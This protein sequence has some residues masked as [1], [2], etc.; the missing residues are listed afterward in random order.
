VSNARMDMGDV[1]IEDVYQ[2]YGP[3]LLRRARMLL[4]DEQ[5]AWDA[6]QEVFVR[7]LQAGNQFR[8]EAS[9]MSWL[10]RITT[11]HCLNRLR[12]GGRRSHLLRAQLGNASLAFA[13]DGELSLAV[14]EVLRLLPR[15]V[16]EIAIYSHVDRMSH[17]EIAALLDLS[18]RTVR[19]RLREFQTRAQT[20]LGLTLEVAS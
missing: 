19:N 17:D 5:A 13:P 12:D 14:R 4:G 11:N 16:C 8:H 7:A 18:P 6:V 15:D 3:L 2:R 1:W 10:Y 20:A 9:P